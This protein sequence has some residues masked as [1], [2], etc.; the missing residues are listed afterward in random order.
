MTIDCRKYLAALN[1]SKKTIDLLWNKTEDKQLAV[2][3]FAVS[4][5]IPIVVVCLFV[6]ECYGDNVS[7]SALFSS[8]FDFY[9]YSTVIDFNNNEISEL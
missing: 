8:L 5:G 9:R 3:E 7:I 4:S 6:I 2:V 1:K